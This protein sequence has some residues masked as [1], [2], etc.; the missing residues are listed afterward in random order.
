MPTEIPKFLKFGFLFSFLFL[1]SAPAYAQ[2]GIGTQ[3]FEF[4]TESKGF[5]KTKFKKLSD[6]KA[7]VAKYRRSFNSRTKDLD[8]RCEDRFGAGYKLNGLSV[9]ERAVGYMNEDLPVDKFQWKR[10]VAEV[11]IQCVKS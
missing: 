4:R 2:Q 9:K 1:I 11:Y 8:K 5:E 10:L 6:A 7:A 3:R